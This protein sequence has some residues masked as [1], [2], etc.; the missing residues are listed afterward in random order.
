MITKLFVK[1]KDGIEYTLDNEGIQSKNE[2]QDIELS[3]IQNTL[4]FLFCYFTKES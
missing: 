2:N 4:N 1:N 3:D